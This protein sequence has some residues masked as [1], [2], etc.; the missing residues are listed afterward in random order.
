MLTPTKLIFGCFGF[1]AMTFLGLAFLQT[2]VIGPQS[3]VQGDPSSGG[4]AFTA[5]VLAGSACR[6]AAA[7]IPAV[8]QSFSDSGNASLRRFITSA[9]LES[10]AMAKSMQSHF[11]NNYWLPEIAPNWIQA[12]VQAASRILNGKTNTLARKIPVVRACESAR[13][14]LVSAR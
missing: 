13:D 3:I 9:H 2:P 7:K 4:S 5:L 11:D 1:G 10:E 8:L 14:Q 12:G 6:N